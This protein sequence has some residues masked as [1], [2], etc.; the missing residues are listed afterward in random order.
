MFCCLESHFGVRNNGLFT[1]VSHYFPIPLNQKISAA[2][3]MPAVTY[4][5]N[6]FGNFAPPLD[7]YRNLGHN[8]FFY[9]KGR[10]CIA[11]GAIASLEYLCM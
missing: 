8:Y 7:R 6:C 2:P 3:L 4:R 9:G 10:Y 11:E 1:E 5:D